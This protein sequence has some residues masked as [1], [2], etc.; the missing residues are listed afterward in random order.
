MSFEFMVI[1]A[2]RQPIGG[3]P[4]TASLL[5]PSSHKPWYGMY[6]HHHHYSANDQV[7]AEDVYLLTLKG[8]NG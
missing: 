4:A 2:G 6:H 3:S 5:A 1:T 8:R 7:Q